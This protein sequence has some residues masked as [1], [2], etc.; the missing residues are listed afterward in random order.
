ML[1]VIQENGNRTYA[2]ALQCALVDFAGYT[3]AVVAEK[4]T[5]NAMLEQLVPLLEAKKNIVFI[6]TENTDLIDA[7][8]AVE[9]FDYVTTII[10]A[11]DK[12]RPDKYTKA[13]PWAYNFYKV[14]HDGL[15]T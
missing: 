5:T 8:C 10:G 7:I 13:S 9:E 11:R 14:W 3:K 2:E 12:D 4:S 15:D 1:I 6:A